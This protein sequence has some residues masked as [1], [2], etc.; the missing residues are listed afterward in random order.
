MCD[1]GSVSPL[2]AA[3]PR[4]IDLSKANWSLVDESVTCPKCLKRLKAARG[5]RRP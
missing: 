4:A 5:E 1:D 3:R 2:C